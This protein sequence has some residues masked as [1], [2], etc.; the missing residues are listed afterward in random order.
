MYLKIVFICFS[1]F[2]N[3]NCGFLILNEI[4]KAQKTGYCFCAS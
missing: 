4:K 3:I 2:F 1:Y